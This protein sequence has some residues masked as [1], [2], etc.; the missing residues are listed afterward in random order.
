MAASGD[1]VSLTA[2]ALGTQEVERGFTEASPVDQEKVDQIRQSIADGSY[3]LRP[4]RIA[5]KLL[6]FEELL[7]GNG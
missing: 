4:D 3:S 7:A 1:T 5:E 6:Q 2:R